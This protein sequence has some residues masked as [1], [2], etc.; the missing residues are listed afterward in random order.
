MHR[1]YIKLWRCI[2]DN[3]FYFSE[4]FTKAQAW[5]D[6]ILIAN[7]KEKIIYVRGV[8]VLIKRGFVGYSEEGLAKRWGWSRDK[9]RRF[10]NSMEIRQ[11]IRQHKSSTLSQIEILK[12]DLYQPSNTID[13]TT[14]NTR[15]KH[16]KNTNKNEKNEKEKGTANK[17]KYLEFVFLTEEEHQK[18]KEQFKYDL[19]DKIETLNN[20]IG[21]TGK[22]YKSHYHTILNW[23]KKD[24]ETNK[25]I[26]LPT[27]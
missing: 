18:L 10:K 20:Y 12:Y 14:D 5:V 22:R 23:A 3:D 4:K 9:V 6:L 15:E 24:K 17:K 16:Q 11:Q 7:H 25:V 1:G 27:I 21:S 8:E 26:K 2:E 13:N 19:D